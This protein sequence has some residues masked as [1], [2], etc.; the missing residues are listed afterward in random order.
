MSQSEPRIFISYSA[1]ESALAQALCAF[2][3][4]QGL[5]CWI[6]PRDMEV[7][8]SFSQTIIEKIESSYALILILS[9]T[10]NDSDYV[11]SEIANAFQRK[12][13]VLEF[14]I[15]PIAL[16]KRLEL[17]LRMQH[18]L[19]ATTGRPEDHFPMLYNHCSA[20]HAR[21]ATQTDPTP[22]QLNMTQIL[23]LQSEIKQPRPPTSATAPPSQTKVT[24]RLV[25]TCSVFFVIIGLVLAITLYLAT[26]KRDGGKVVLPGPPTNA[27]PMKD[28]LTP[29]KNK[30]RDS[31]VHTDSSSDQPKHLNPPVSKAMQALEG[32]TFIDGPS[33]GL[34]KSDD[35]I[36]FSG[37]QGNSIQFN[38]HVSIYYISGKMRIIGNNLVIVNADPRCSGNM[39][40][41]SGGAKLI[42]SFKVFTS[43][44]PTPVELSRQEQ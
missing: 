12:I 19:D 30:P 18:H 32:A 6:A 26:P 39:S 28:S 13:P 14:R 8:N 36:S 21:Q 35:K 31:I 40:V 20:T 42:G 34:V 5:S 22:Q 33:P 15:H 16:H 17:Y 29:E 4:T 11:F 43:D 9:R 23:P 25:V 7:G 24:P 27:V 2:L 10:S 38:L 1:T 41:V 3:E 44:S 37:L